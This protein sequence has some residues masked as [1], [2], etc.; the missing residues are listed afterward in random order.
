MIGQN[1]IV[2][3]KQSS[4][5]KTVDQSMGKDSAEPLERSVIGVSK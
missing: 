4:F 1:M 5:V 3:V 2:G